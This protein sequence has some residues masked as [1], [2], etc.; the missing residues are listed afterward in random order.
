MH[1][2]PSLAAHNGE[3]ETATILAAHNGEYGISTMC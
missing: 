3:Y 2:L 1:L